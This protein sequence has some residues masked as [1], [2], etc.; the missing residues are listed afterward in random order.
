MDNERLQILVRRYRQGDEEAGREL[1]DT[2]R[3]LISALAGRMILEPAGSEEDYCQSGMIGLLKAARRFK[4]DAGVK[5][6]TF[7]VPWIR[8][9][10]LQNR[11]NNHSPLKVSRSLKEQAGLLGYHRERLAQTLGRE[12]T[13]ADLSKAMGVDPE[14]ITLIMESTMPLVSLGEEMPASREGMWEEEEL[15]D[16][17]SLQEGMMKLTPLDRKVIFLRYYRELSQAEIGRILSLTQR[18]VSRLEKRI[19]RQLRRLLN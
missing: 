17:L 15:V 16:H 7:A 13:V 1:A 19:L 10:M 14:E 3:P 6:I 2:V 18:Q 9:E 4:P 8:G 12:P 11:R 5:F